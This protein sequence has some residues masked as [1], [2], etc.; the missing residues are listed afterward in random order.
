M[1]KR[2]RLQPEH[3]EEESVYWPGGLVLVAM[4]LVG[5]AA[6][7]WG[8]HLNGFVW[9][10]VLAAATCLVTGIAFMAIGLFELEWLER[11][12]GFVDGILSGVIQWFWTRWFGTLSESEFVGRSRARVIWVVFGTFAFLGGCALAAGIL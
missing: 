11:I 4:I 10:N 3:H 6:L 12:V 9:K 2:K 7:G 1:K 5:T 8:C